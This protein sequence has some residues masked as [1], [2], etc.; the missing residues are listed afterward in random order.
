MRVNLPHQVRAAIYILTLVGTPII[1]YLFT[2]HAI[3]EPVVA[4]WGAEV[5]VAN[6]IAALNV[7]NPKPVEDTT[8]QSVDDEV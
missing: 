4:L 3:S 2:I 7:T 8:D 1:G 6:T 5:A